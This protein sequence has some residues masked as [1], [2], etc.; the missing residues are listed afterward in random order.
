LV[1]HLLRHLGLGPFRGFP[2]L[3]FLS[4]K[5]ALGA[6]ILSKPGFLHKGSSFLGWRTLLVVWASGLSFKFFPGDRYLL[7]DFWFNPLLGGG[8][9]NWAPVTP[10]FWGV[11]PG[12]FFLAKAKGGS[13]R[14]PFCGGPP[15]LFFP[16]R[17]ID[18]LLWGS[19][20]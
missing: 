12:G 5:G 15:N 7:I 17:P 13:L 6:S 10:L 1:P 4:N 14:P 20:P 18:S 2:T 3:S 8:F 11:D 9:F 19:S 16:L